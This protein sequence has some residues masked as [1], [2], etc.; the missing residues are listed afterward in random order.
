MLRKSMIV[1]SLM[2][3]ATFMATAFVAVQSNVTVTADLTAIENDAA[4]DYWSN[5]SSDLEN[6]IAERLV[7]PIA[8]SSP[9][10]AVDLREGAMASS[11]DA[12]LDQPDAVLVGQVNVSDPQNHQSVDGFVLRVSL[13]STPKVSANSITIALGSRDPHDAYHSLISAFADGV[14]ERLES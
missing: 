6:A 2:M 7:G 1:L 13:G 5:V 4:A 8:A 3:M 9:M 14:V 12:A 11:F 10:I